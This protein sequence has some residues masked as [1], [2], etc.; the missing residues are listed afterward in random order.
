[1][2]GAFH[3]WAFGALLGLRGTAELTTSPGRAAMM[4]LGLH[5]D[6]G[7]GMFWQQPLLF[8]GVA[9][10]VPFVRR[11]PTLALIWL[12]VYA[13]LIVPDALELARYGGGAPAGRFGWSAAWLWIVPLGYMFERSSVPAPGGPGFSW[14]IKPIVFTCLAYQALLASRWLPDPHVLFPVLEEN[15]VARNSLFPIAMRAWLPSFYFWDFSS[16]WTYGPNLLAYAALGALL[17]SGTVLFRSSH[18]Y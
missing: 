1:M 7:Q 18:L 12:G 15:L 16:Y 8:A 4:L 11:R 2:L 3:L 6:Q 10:L 14:T 17:L 13:S 9:A 5:L